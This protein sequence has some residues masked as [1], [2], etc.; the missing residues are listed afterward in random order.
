VGY[1]PEPHACI[2]LLQQYNHICVAGNHD[3]AAIGMIDI[4]DFNEDAAL[5]NQ[6]TTQQLT[7]KDKE[8]LKSL[9]QVISE[10]DFSLV[11]GSP[12]EPL[13]EYLF[14]TRAAEE[15]LELFTTRFCLVG[16]SHIPLIFEQLP[17]GMKLTKLDANAIISLKENRLIINP[18]SV[19]QPRD[20]DPRASYV[21]Y[22]SCTE[23]LCHHRVEY[24]IKA[25]QEKMLQEKLPEFLIL[26]LNHGM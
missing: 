1:G 20:H 22:D 19:G 4:L 13:W 26:R 18:G 15:N 6:W 8:Y 12:R 11:H 3:W 16:H 23:I 5:A 24:D 7:E 17:E 14:S 25:T 21:I 10:H 9:P 2:E